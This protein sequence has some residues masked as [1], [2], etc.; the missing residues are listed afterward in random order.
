MDVGND[1]ERQLELIAR[2][3]TEIVPIAELKAKLAKA[4]RENKP[5]QI[6]LGLD[7]TAPSIHI[8][9]AVVLRKM[10]LFQ[11]LGHEVTIIIGDFTGMIGDPT[12]RSDARVQL[13]PEKV[14][15]NAKTYEEQ[16]HKI[17]DPAR[18]R[19]VFNSEW[20]GP[21]KM[22]DVVNLLA[23]TTVARI[24]ERDEFSKRYAAGQPVHMHEL[25][26]PIM[27]GYDSVFLKSDVEI[28]GT[29]QRFNIMMGR[30][31]QREFGIEPQIAL[32]MPILVGLDGVEKMSKS[33]GNYVGI[34]EPA[35]DIFGK[36]MS[37]S[38]EM[39]PEYF[40]LCTDI[41]MADVRALTDSNA[42]HPREAKKRLAREIVALY[43]G[44]DA[45]SAAD[46][47]FER[48][49]GKGKASDAI[50]DDTP[51]VPISAE[52]LDA[53]GG[54]R[55][56]AL[57]VAAGLAPTG[58]EAKRLV[59][60]GGVGIDGQKVGDPTQSV[61]VRTGMIVKVGK[62]RFARLIAPSC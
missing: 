13:T 48:V 45:A 25:L 26:Y 30:D 40:E 10:R 44:P 47:E 35:G 3:T 5:L 59:Q 54:I 51:D 33:K 2:G 15:A 60:Q 20:L 1:I 24:L 27:Q 16:Y 22:Y 31:L 57:L 38:D 58:S 43:H 8:G 29:D 53:E 50:P 4:A 14:A 21:L 6:K 49:H 23:K 12:G 46:E 34:D 56:A 52:L 28:G 18:T 42:T 41:P 61:R 11:D 55:V 7:P 32:F 62:N 9:H 36:I 17:L 39:M 19:V 37:I